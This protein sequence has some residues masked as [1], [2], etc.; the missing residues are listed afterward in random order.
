MLCIKICRIYMMTLSSPS[1]TGSQLSVISYHWKPLRKL[2]PLNWKAMSDIGA[3]W[4][5]KF[6][7]IKSEGSSADAS[8][9]LPSSFVP[10]VWQKRLKSFKGQS[11]KLENTE[12]F[13]HLL[14]SITF[15]NHLNTI[16]KLFFSPSFHLT[17]RR[18]LSLIE[19]RTEKHFARSIESLDL[20]QWLL[21]SS[22]EWQPQGNK[23]GMMVWLTAFYVFSLQGQMYPK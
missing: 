2:F 7:C 4:S 19:R 5:F 6:S 10:Q 14:P 3:L 20:S 8:T 15:C 18:S 13:N 23:D 16:L 12:L 9:H 11:V 21:D 1:N 22:G 17:L